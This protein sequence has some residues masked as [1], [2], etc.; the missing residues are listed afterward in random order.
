VR[1]KIAVGI[2]VA[3]FNAGCAGVPSKPDTAAVPKDCT[4]GEL[5][6]PYGLSPEKLAISGEVFTSL[7]SKSAKG[8]VNGDDARLD[9]RL[10]W[11]IRGRSAPL[12]A[13]DHPLKMNAAGTVIGQVV[14][15]YILEADG[16][17]SWDSVLESSGDKDLDAVALR[18]FRS[19]TYKA[20]ATLD[21]KPVRAYFTAAFGHKANN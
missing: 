17:V 9:G 10:V 6:N 15:A 7:C 8:L 12:L 14:V 5:R 13:L 19:I 18:F 21:G 20:P 4:T 16:Q 1:S 11:P 2:C 3:V